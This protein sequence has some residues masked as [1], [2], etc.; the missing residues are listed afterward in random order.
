MANLLHRFSQNSPGS[1]KEE[2]LA[3]GDHDSSRFTASS[4]YEDSLFGS[5]RL[6]RLARLPA[7][8]RLSTRR[9]TLAG[10]VGMG[11]ICS[12]G[13]VGHQFA[14]TLMGWVGDQPEHQISFTDVELIPPPPPFIESGTRGILESVRADSKRN[15]TLSV[16]G[17]DLEALRVDFSRNPW[18]ASAGPI[19]ATYRHLSLSVV[20]R[21]PVALIVD[22]NEKQG[23]VIDQNGVE[24]SIRS[25]QLKP[26]PT[27]QHSRV[28]GDADD[29]LEIRGFRSRLPN[30]LGMLWKSSNPDIDR[31]KVLQASRLAKF[32]Q[33]HR[34]TCSPQGRPSPIF[35]DIYYHHESIKGSDGK[36][37]LAKGFFLV[38]LEKNCVWWGSGPGGEIQDEPKAEE[39]WATML[40]FM[41][42]NGGII[43]KS[44]DQQ[45][46]SLMARRPIL[47]M[48]P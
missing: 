5:P 7:V 48:V 31:S 9:L 12:V 29:L 16:L 47:I 11:L 17:S 26:S 45:F 41:D 38:D 27:S 15:P 14:R 2:P 4:E 36:T 42:G 13:V 3:T 22:E 28:L 24:L 37:E 8:R 35:L 21:R 39:K 33:D 46:L 30:Q 43:H 19:Y 25:S 6:E 1:M 23:A 32:L 44:N 10:V 20:Y 34:G 40:R 18:I